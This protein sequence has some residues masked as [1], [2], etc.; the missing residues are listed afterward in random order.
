MASCGI[1]GAQERYVGDLV[2]G[3]DGIPECRQCRTEPAVAKVGP[4]ASRTHNPSDALGAGRA[5]AAVRKIPTVSQF[6]PGRA[7]TP[8]PGF[9]LERVRIA[10]SDGSRRDSVEAE[11]TFAGKPW[12]GELRYLGQARGFHVFER[13]PTGVMTSD[14]L[15]RPERP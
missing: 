12:R 7:F 8:T 6:G 2:R 13:P 5:A 11:M 4:K 10:A 15:V 9:H 14:R 3:E 1:C